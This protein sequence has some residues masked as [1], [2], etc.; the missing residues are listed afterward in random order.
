M[1]KILVIL[2][3]KMK[4]ITSKTFAIKFK[5]NNL[6]KSRKKNFKTDSRTY[7]DVTNIFV[8]STILDNRLDSEYA[9]LLCLQET[10]TFSKG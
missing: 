1:M 8:K 9:Y 4:T 7:V 2:V 6:I 3:R 5:I 10:K